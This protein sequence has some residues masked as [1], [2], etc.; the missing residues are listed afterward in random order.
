MGTSLQVHPFASLVD[1]VDRD[2][3]RLLINREAVGVFAQRKLFSKR[4]DSM[5]LGDTDDAVRILARELKW[6]DELDELIA[7]GRRELEIKWAKQEKLY[8]EGKSDKAKAEKKAD[9]S[10]E[11]TDDKEAETAAKVKA[12]PPDD[13]DEVDAL[14]D[15][16]GKVEIE[17][18]PAAK[19]DEK[20]DTKPKAKV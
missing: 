12:T 11:K 2:T 17:A 5:F 20:E 16:I 18:K 13:D 9:D 8:D 6:E 3:P 15:K 10:K 7:E 1:V 19:D 4:K 14:A